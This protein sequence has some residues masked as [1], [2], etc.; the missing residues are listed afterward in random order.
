[1]KG[2]IVTKEELEKQFVLYNHT[3]N[4][5][6]RQISDLSANASLAPTQILELSKVVKNVKLEVGKTA[7]GFY[8]HP[9]QWRLHLLAT[10]RRQFQRS[11]YDLIVDLW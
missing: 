4:K 7:S 6:Q 9:R 1:M 2:L 11:T 3:H 5:A 10:Y 8:A